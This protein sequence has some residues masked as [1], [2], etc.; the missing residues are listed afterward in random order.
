M[1]ISGSPWY[2]LGGLVSGRFCWGV[3]G[4][5]DVFLVFAL[6]RAPLRA[7]VARRGDA[8]RRGLRARGAQK[9]SRRTRGSVGV[10]QPNQLRPERLYLQSHHAPKQDP[11]EGRRDS[12]S[13]GL[14]S[15]RDAA[16]CVAVRARHLWVQ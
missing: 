5:S 8:Y 3:R 14:Q 11:G 1:E 9:A 16:L 4:G 6:A 10:V 13:T 2:P 15:V 7:V 12:K